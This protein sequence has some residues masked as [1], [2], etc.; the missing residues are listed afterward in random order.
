M[1]NFQTM[2]LPEALKRALQNMQFSTPT[3]I[4]SQVI[5]LALAGKDIL[6]SAQTGTG[7]KDNPKPSAKK[8]A[9]KAGFL[10]GAFIM[11]P[12]FDE[13]LEDFKEYMA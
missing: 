7:K 2:A 1:T 5:P 4:Q 11:S 8:A 10:K 9:P 3:P 12:D 13:P 6:G